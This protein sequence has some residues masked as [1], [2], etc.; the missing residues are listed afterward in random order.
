MDNKLHR[1]S[2]KDQVREVL[3]EQI[4][5]GE[6]PPGKRVKIIPI[7]KALN[8][9]QAPVREA[10]Q[11]LATSGY[12]EVV[13]NAGVRVKAFSDEEIA[14]MFELRKML[15]F[16]CFERKDFNSNNLASMLNATL[17]E[18]VN[19]INEEDFK[20]YAKF[21]SKFHRQFVEASHNS[22]MLDVWDSFSI[23]IN[24]MNMVHDKKTTKQKV[25]LYHTPII[26]AL[27]LGDLKGAKLHLE[28]HYRYI[29]F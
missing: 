17:R 19:S 15:E 23:P 8:I 18:M 25:L 22:K 27:F 24:I 12:L 26:N 21:D 1:K 3:L 7:S 14:E 28:N 10:I 9:S 13:P 4:R 20:S 2:L 16:V 5:T 29:K 6:L 11:C